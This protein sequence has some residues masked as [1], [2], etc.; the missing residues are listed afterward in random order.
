MKLLYTICNLFSLQLSRNTL[1]YLVAVLTISFHE[2]IAQP[3]A[4][5]V[6]PTSFEIE[7]RARNGNSGFEGALFTPSTPAPGQLGGG[8]WRMNPA[9]SPVWNSNGNSYGDVHHFIFVY[10][11]ATGTSTWKIDFNRDGDFNDVSESVTSTS[12]S[13]VGKSFRYVNL[14]GQGSSTGFSSTLSNLL[15]NGVL[16][17]GT[18]V[19]NSTTPFNITYEDSTG[20]FNDI[21]VC[22]SL[23]FSGNAGQ[24]SP[25]LW[26]RCSSTNF[27]PVINI[28]NPL[29]GSITNLN[30]P[31]T[32]DA[33]ATDPD[34]SIVAVKFYNGTTLLGA[35][36]TSPYSL[37]WNGAPAG[38]NTITVSAIDNNGEISSASVNV[39]VN[40]PPSVV[41]IT[42]PVAGDIIN[43]NTP[44]TITANATDADGTIALV[45]FYNG[46]T[47]LGVDSTSPYS[48]VWNGATA[49]N[50]TITVKAIDNN[51]ASNSTSVSILVNTPPSAVVITS[52][53]AG[54]IINLNTPITITANATDADG[55]IALVE[56]YNG[57]TLLG[58][59]STSPYSFVWNGAKTGNNTITVK[60]IDNNRAST[61]ASVNIVVNTPPSVSITSPL[62]GS[63]F[64]LNVPITIT[65]N[66]SD[67]DGTIA[68]VEFY[69]GT[70]LL[71]TD[72]TSPYEYIWNSSFATPGNNTVTAKAIDNN[73]S[74]SI[75]SVNL[76]LSTLSPFTTAIVSPLSGQVF[77]LNSPVLFST[78]TSN[79]DNQVAYVEFILNGISLA[80]DSFAPYS[81]TA[82]SLPFGT[83]FVTAR[84]VDIYGASINSSVVN[85][86]VNAP[87]TCAI[88]SPINNATLAFPGTITINTNCTDPEGNIAKVEFFQDAVKI[89]EDLTAPFN[90]I[91]SNIVLGNYTFSAKVT[92][93]Y[94]A[95]AD[96]IPVSVL[97][98]CVREDLN[99]DNVVNNLDFLLLV[100]QFGSNC[101][102]GCQA[103]FNDD[104]IVDNV[105]FLSFLTR[106]NF[107][108]N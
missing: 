30:S 46:A 49:G 37:V 42:S 73:G 70:T 85:F 87:P 57:T 12:P 2:A 88:T 31:V 23:A 66:A 16:F 104:G 29:N 108:C 72:N 93:N 44:I 32:I 21:I 8:A 5:S 61:S 52:P 71:G 68:L 33:T 53:V 98:K 18:F 17:P 34:G 97:V 48:F 60:A 25:R 101:A 43:L 67:A 10:V 3:I 102:G 59:D 40:T 50:N 86:I 89:G 11:K 39:F 76:I 62:A 35:D 81:Y 22:G 24:E 95:T 99:N 100:S 74:S 65:A 27:P 92:D 75:A 63:I 90:F 69:N 4:S 51:G 20:I 58:V 14:Y 15:I 107:I 91:A 96:A 28:T 36:N 78:V 6:T 54:D 38:N 84:T 77:N 7:A 26:V 103:D 55:T 1:V 79:Q 13:L 9:G 94:G 64:P 82:N 56:F 47:L 105:D 80:I 45:E 19:S 41:M 106:F 83:Y